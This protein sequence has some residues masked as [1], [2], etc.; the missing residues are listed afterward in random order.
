MKIFKHHHRV[1]RS[2]HYKHSLKKITSVENY[3]PCIS[4]ILN[5][6]RGSDEELCTDFQGS[7][8]E[9]VLGGG[10]GF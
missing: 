4:I 5:F 7:I 1:G 9:Y 3:L 8:K 10:V 2:N 6:C